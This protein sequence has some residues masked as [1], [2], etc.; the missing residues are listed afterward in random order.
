M[1]NKKKGNN[2]RQFWN[3]DRMLKAAVDEVLEARMD[4]LKAS[5][6]FEISG[7]PMNLE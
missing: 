3:E 7:K 1:W 5:K 2:D 4:Y 6:Q